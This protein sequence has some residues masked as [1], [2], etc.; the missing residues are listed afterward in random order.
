MT[1]KNH[2]RSKVEIG[3]T[4]MVLDWE[5]RGGGEGKGIF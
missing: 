2:A 4:F 1:K 5:R 3:I